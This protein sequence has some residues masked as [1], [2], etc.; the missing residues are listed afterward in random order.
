M[1][2]DRPVPPVPDLPKIARPYLLVLFSVP[3]YLDDQGRRFLEP[4]WAKDLIEHTR[5]IERLVLA[6]PARR[7]EMPANAIAIDTVEALRRVTCVEL[8]PARSYLG[9]IRD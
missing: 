2:A 5:Y 3:F 4:L 8:P 7:D 6:A 9:A 1:T